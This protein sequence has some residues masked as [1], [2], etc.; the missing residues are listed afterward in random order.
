MKSILLHIEADDCME[1]RLQFALDL[2]RAHNGHITCLQAVNFEIFAPGDFYGSAMA[3]ALPAL[4]KAADELRTELEERLTKED[5]SWEWQYKPGMAETKLLELAALQD[6]VLVGPR[7]VG[8]KRRH[9][10]IMVGELLLRSSTPVIVVPQKWKSYDPTAPVLVAWNGSPEA[11]IALRNAV[12][13]LKTASKVILARVI[14]EKESQAEEFPMIEGS[15]YLSRHDIESEL[16]EIPK[17]KAKVSDTLFTNAFAKDCGMVV[18]GAYGHMRITEALF[19][20]VTRRSLTDP[21]LPIFL[22]H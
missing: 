4:Q 15:L 2:A 8:E 17:G 7:D 5:V 10:S 18:M 14:E 12:P 19:G 3:A 16:L 11:C 13:M 9:P 21:Q 1:A 22:A 20:G 6:V